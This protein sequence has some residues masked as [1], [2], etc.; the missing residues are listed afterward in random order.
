MKNM[1][2]IK[3]FNNIKIDCIS[4]K[5]V[6]TWASNIFN[7]NNCIIPGDLN[8]DGTLNVLD[9]V[10][11]ANCILAN[12]CADHENGCAGDMNNDGVFN[13]LDI[14]LLA[15]CVLADNCSG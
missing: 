13:V 10:Q 11:L 2:T 15:N 1:K 8:N 4:K 14:V 9:I 6:L 7:Q 5:E 3:L 12:N